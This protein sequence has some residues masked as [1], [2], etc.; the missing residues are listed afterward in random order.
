MLVRARTA[1]TP[2]DVGLPAGNR[3]RVAGLRREEVAQLAG[4]STD[5]V[6]R[7]EQGRGPQPST[8]VLAA[9][10]RALRMNDDARDELFHLAGSAPPL[11]GQAGSS[12]A[13]ARLPTSPHSS[14]RNDPVP[15]RVPDI[16]DSISAPSSVG[17]A[18]GSWPSRL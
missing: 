17:A 7:L 11:P 5:Y 18:T 9:L 12:S 13:A 2:Q 8:Q 1:L 6:V 10:A 14:Q 4:V 16:I 15:A 3:R